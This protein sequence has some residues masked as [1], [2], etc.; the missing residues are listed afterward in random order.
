LHRELP[1]PCAAAFE[2][3][4]RGK[5]QYVKKLCMWPQVDF[6]KIDILNHW[7]KSSID[8]T[9]S[10][11]WKVLH[12]GLKNSGLKYR[13]ALD[14]LKSSVVDFRCI[15]TGIIIYSDFSI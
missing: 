4:R 3:A 8:L 13:V 12:N 6:S 5:Y 11:D 10:I 2:V 1:D 15:N 9:K 14:S 7:K